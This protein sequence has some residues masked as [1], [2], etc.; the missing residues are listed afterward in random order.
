MP[1]DSEDWEKLTKLLNDNKRD[2]ADSFA[3]ELTK[4]NSS[5][6]L[7]GKR[8]RRLE[9]GYDHNA[10]VARAAIVEV[11]RRDHDRLLRA[12]FD[13]SVLLLAPTWADDGGGTRVKNPLKCS[14]DDVSAVITECVADTVKFEIELADKVGY[15]ILVASHSPQAR[16]KGAASIVKKARGL[17]EQ[18]LQLRLFYD[19]PYDLR[20]LQREGHKF[21]GEVRRT[22]GDSVREKKIEKGYFTINGVRIAPEFLLPGPSRWDYLAKAVTEKVRGWR[23]RPP[24]SF[25]ECGVLYDT[26]AAEFAAEKGVVDL[27]DLEY[28]DLG[29]SEDMQE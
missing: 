3:T 27:Q 8:L 12:T 7:T 4:L 2:I 13:D 22:G 29:E 21:L 9:T 19:K 11:A 28:L 20:V 24:T 17:L 6:T 14:M 10:K 1:L 25:A 26:F 18:R 5:L 23:G 16:R 15:R